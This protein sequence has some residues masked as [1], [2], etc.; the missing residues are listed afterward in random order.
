M[1]IKMI[2]CSLQLENSFSYL[3][4]LLSCVTLARKFRLL[5]IFQY[6]HFLF[7][8]CKEEMS[9]FLHDLGSLKDS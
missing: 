3:K 4:T 5:S 6:Y 8:V 1:V 2:M 7:R 9:L